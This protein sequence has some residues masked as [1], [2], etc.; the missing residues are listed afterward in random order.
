MSLRDVG[1]ELVAAAAARAKALKS[2]LTL[3]AKPKDILARLRRSRRH[4]ELNEAP[5]ATDWLWVSRAPEKTTVMNKAGE[6]E[7]RFIWRKGVTF[8]KGRNEMK[9]KRRAYHESL[10]GP[11]SSY[12]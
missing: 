4:R 2:S 7:A 1:A 11:S 9:R 12:V 5:R 6:L 10:K 3:A 8:N